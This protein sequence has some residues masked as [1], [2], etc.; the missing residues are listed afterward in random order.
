[1]PA[2]IIEIGSGYSTRIADKALRRNRAE[3]RGGALI[4]IEPYQLFGAGGKLLAEPRPSR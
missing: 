2:H 4:C 3:G 1:M